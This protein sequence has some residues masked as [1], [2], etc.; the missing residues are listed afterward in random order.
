[1]SMKSTAVK[2]CG[3]CDEKEA[4]YQC[5]SCEADNSYFCEECWKVHVKVKQFRAHTYF[6]ISPKIICCNC[7]QVNASTK[8]LQCNVLDS[9]FCEDCSLIHKQVKAFRSHTIVPLNSRSHMPPHKSSS[10]KTTTKVEPLEISVSEDPATS[11]MDYCFGLFLRAVDFL[12]IDVGDNSKRGD[13]Y[14]DW[15]IESLGDITSSGDMDHK[16]IMFGL[17]VAFLVHVVVKLLLGNNSIFVMI[18]VGMFGVRWL[19]RKQYITV[20]EI[21]ALK[22][23][24]SIALINLIISH[25][26]DYC[27]GTCR[28]ILRSSTK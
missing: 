20:T 11:A 21:D 4:L 8:C 16:T 26:D 23:V 18:A 19:R 1:M 13:K 5:T 22:S 14:F 17:T 2:K 3:N 12:K 24:C 9:H 28:R 27:C 7:D 10:T 15:I 25:F 6:E